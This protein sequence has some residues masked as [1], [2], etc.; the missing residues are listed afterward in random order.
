MQKINVQNR[1]NVNDQH[2]Q[3]RLAAAVQSSSLTHPQSTVHMAPVRKYHIVSVFCCFQAYMS[4]YHVISPIGICLTLVGLF[5]TYTQSLLHMF[6]H[7]YSVWI[8]TQTFNWESCV[9]IRC[10][11]KVSLTETWQRCYNRHTERFKFLSYPPSVHTRTQA[12]T[13]THRSSVLQCQSQIPQTL[14]WCLWSKENGNGAGLQ[15]TAAVNRCS[16]K[17]CLQRSNKVRNM[18][19]CKENLNFL[20]LEG[21]KPQAHLKWRPSVI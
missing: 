5:V 6:T 1:Y 8:H 7:A 21:D 12:L 9:F 14:F 15:K 18:R 20:R 16:Q 2:F 13:H 10:P 3:C 19:K 4:S 17:S 11:F